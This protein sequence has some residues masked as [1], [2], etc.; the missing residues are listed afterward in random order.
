MYNNVV[1][2]VY[3]AIADPARRRMLDL[4]ATTPMPAT[5]L[6]AEFTI[7]Q[8]AVSR[9]L[10]SLREADLVTVSGAG[11]G[12]VRLYGVRPQ[13]LQDVERWLTGFWQGQLDAFATHV[14]SRS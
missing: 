3:E 13:P 9:H 11:D 12:R 4:L 2:D 1:M 6:A 5:Q 7:S 14:R 8:P 10:R